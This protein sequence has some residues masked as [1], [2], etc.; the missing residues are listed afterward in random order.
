MVSINQLGLYHSAQLA[1]KL[2]IKCRTKC[3]SIIMVGSSA[4][5]IAV[6]SVN[7]SAYNSTKGGVLAM[8]PS[9][10]KETGPHV[11]LNIHQ[12]PTHQRGRTKRRMGYPLQLSI[13]RLHQNAHDERLP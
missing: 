1:A 6:K 13:S 11:S 2:M 8:V 10:A 12:Y 7:T 4:G 5:Q 9:I 3:G